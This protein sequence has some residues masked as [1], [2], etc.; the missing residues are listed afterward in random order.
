MFEA[1]WGTNEL[2]SSFDSINILRPG[3]HESSQDSWLHV[4][5]APLR[6]GGCAPA[7]I[8]CTRVHLGHQLSALQGSKAVAR[9]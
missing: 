9:A 1:L 2:L 6:R 7:Y 5:Q 4:D 3:E 8:L